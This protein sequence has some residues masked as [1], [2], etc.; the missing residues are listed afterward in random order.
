MSTVEAREGA[1]SGSWLAEACKL[2]LAIRAAA[3]LLA[4]LDATAREQLPLLSCALVLAAIASYVPLRHW[5][6]VAGRLARRPVYLTLEI[7]LNLVILV[8]T[9]T[10]S[11]FYLFTLG[12]AVLAG[13]IYGLPGAA[14]ATT[15]LIGSYLWVFSLRADLD[16]V[17]S[18]FQAT[19][20][21]PALYGLAALAGAAVRS[22]AQ[23]QQRDAVEA[24]TEARAAATE[25]ERARLARDMHDSLAKTVHGLALAGAALAR[26]IERDPEG[27]AADARRLSADAEHAAR[28]A[29]GLIYGLREEGTGPLAAAVTTSV[30]EHRREA[31]RIVRAEVEE[32]SVTPAARHE[33]VQILR[34]ALRNVERHAGA[35]ATVTVTLARESGEALLLVSDDGPG[36]S[37]CSPD[38]LREG[39]HFG[40]IGMRERA[41]LVGG[42]LE[43]EAE[44]G[45]GTIVAARVPLAAMAEAPDER[46]A[47]S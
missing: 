2:V 16:G 12:T 13:L 19:V 46:V 6:R 10:D 31:G 9:G 36:F 4:T 45:A 43:I 7:L 8:L 22:I 27:A 20:G 32:V 39:M 29:R 34:E 15:L 47:A 23:R 37:A 41:E 40:L 17:T 38:E 26:R 35:A 1:R 18:T 24:A 44:P 33:L 3:L 11:P 30:E 42:R 21:Q 28:E 14:L 25:R 5:E